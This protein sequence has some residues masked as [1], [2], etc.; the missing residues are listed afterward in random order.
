MKMENHSLLIKNNRIKFNLIF[1]KYRVEFCDIS[2]TK[3]FKFVFNL[4][5]SK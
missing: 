1:Y 4:P 2:H 3:N 5:L